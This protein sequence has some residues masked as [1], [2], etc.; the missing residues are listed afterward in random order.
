MSQEPDRRRK[1]EEAY[2][3]I[4]VS[5]IYMPYSLLKRAKPD[6][7]WIEVAPPEFPFE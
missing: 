2:D 5:V 6:P 4:A 7:A 1:D 3:G